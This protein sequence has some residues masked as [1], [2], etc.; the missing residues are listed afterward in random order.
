MH[1]QRI[2]SVCVLRSIQTKSHLIV[3]CTRVFRILCAPSGYLLPKSELVFFLCF[4]FSH[5][6]RLAWFSLSLSNRLDTVSSCNE[7]TRSSGKCARN[8]LF[9]LTAKETNWC[10]EP[11]EADE[12]SI[13]K[14][15]E[16]YSRRIHEKKLIW[17][18]IDRGPSTHTSTPAW[19]FFCF[20]I[21]FFEILFFSCTE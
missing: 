2:F 20:F 8:F 17:M 4:F 13:E 5:S 14:E 9:R 16:N 11:N 1:R 19:Y 3:A 15:F 18:V 12:E 6:W 10:S 21:S 7:A